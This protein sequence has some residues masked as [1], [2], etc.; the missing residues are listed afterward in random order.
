MSIIVPLS[1]CLKLILSTLKIRR[2][3]DALKMQP[4][5]STLK[6]QPDLSGLKMQPDLSGLMSII[7]PSSSCLKLVLS[8]LKIRRTLDALKIESDLLVSEAL[9]VLCPP[10][11]HGTEDSYHPQVLN[12]IVVLLI[13]RT[14]RNCTFLRLQEFSCL[15]CSLS[16][17]DLEYSKSSKM[18][19]H[20]QPWRQMCA[21]ILLSWRYNWSL[22]SLSF[23]SQRATLPSC[24]SYL[25]DLSCIEHT[26]VLLHKKLERTIAS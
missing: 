7:V 4:D 9:G 10:C 25:E 14:W 26:K 12:C 8:P 16:L 23:V 13:W 19:L 3:L 21:C 18:Y 6:M 2:T 24:S 11:R 22:S 1:S 15:D 5:L 17:Q 20:L